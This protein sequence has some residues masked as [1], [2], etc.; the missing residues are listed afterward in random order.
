MIDFMRPEAKAVIARWAETA[1]ATLLTLIVT[2]ALLKI[3]AD[4]AAWRDRRRELAEGPEPIVAPRGETHGI[5]QG[6]AA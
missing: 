4:L 2:P 5:Y 1:V 3:R 6:F